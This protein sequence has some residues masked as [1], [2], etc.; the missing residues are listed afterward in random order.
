MADE[1]RDKRDIH[2]LTSIHDP[3]TAGN[4]CDEKGML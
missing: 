1:R 3:P 4:V 2:M